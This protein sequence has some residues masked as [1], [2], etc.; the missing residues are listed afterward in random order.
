MDLYDYYFK[1]KKEGEVD[2]GK[3]AE[4][5]G[6]GRCHLSQLIHGRIPPSFTLANRIEKATNG[7]VTMLEMMA[8]AKKKLKDMPK[9]YQP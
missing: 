3:M 4:L 7:K 1:L 6:C 8:F 2:V 5:F 9:Q